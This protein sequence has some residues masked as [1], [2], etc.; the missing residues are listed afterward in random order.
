MVGYTSS[1]N[2]EFQGRMSASY[3]LRFC[4]FLLKPESL[5]NASKWLV[6]KSELRKIFDKIYKPKQLGLLIDPKR[7]D[8]ICIFDKM[9]FHFEK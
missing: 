9:N 2:A 8:F 4:D 3:A 1:R 7:F 6:R 5:E